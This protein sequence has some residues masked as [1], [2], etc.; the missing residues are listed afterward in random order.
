MFI[1]NVKT[2]DTLDSASITTPHLFDDRD[3]AKD[4]LETV[5]RNLASKGWGWMVSDATPPGQLGILLQ[6]DHLKVVI[7]GRPA[8]EAAL[9]EHYKHLPSWAIKLMLSL[10]PN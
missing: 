8:D 4:W 6:K 5:S 2:V 7:S 10:S 3:L 1:V 9:K